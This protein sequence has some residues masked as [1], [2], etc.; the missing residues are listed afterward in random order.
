[1]LIWYIFSGFGIVYQEKSGNPG[2]VTGP[3]A[4]DEAQAAGG[5]APPCR[6]ER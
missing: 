2:H 1:V 6:L 3:E 4:A 5:P